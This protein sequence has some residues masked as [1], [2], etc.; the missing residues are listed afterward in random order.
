MKALQTRSPI[1][2][3]YDEPTLG[4]VDLSIWI[5]KDPTA[6]DI[7]NAPNYTLTSD[8]IDSKVI[9]EVSELI[10]S[11]NQY[12]FESDFYQ[13]RDTAIYVLC[14]ANI[15]DTNNNLIE[16]KYNFLKIR[17]GYVQ[18][19]EHTQIIN[20][21]IT[22]NI[23]NFENIGS[24]TTVTG[25]QSDPFGGNNAFLLEDITDSNLVIAK[26]PLNLTGLHTTSFFIK[27]GINDFY[28]IRTSEGIT[29]RVIF[30]LS[31]NE[32]TFV[33]SEVIAYDLLIVN[34]GFVKISIVTELDLN[35]FF[36]VSSINLIQPESLTLFNPTVVK[37]NYINQTASDLVLQDNTEIFTT[38]DI[39]IEVLFDRKRTNGF[40]GFDSNFKDI[41]DSSPTITS[42]SYNINFADI[43]QDRVIADGGTFESD[44]CLINYL[45]EI[46][47]YDEANDD[48]LIFDDLSGIRTTQLFAF[49]ELCEPKYTPVKIS[50]INRFGVIQDL[51]FFKKRVDSYNTSEEDYKAN[52][53]T[54]GE[55]Y[56][57]LGQRRVYN[58]QAQASVKISSGFY[59]ESFNT[60]FRQLL[61]SE[62]YWI[63]DEPAILTDSKW[64][65]KTKVNDKLINYDFD[66]DFA[67]DDIN[68]IR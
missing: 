30:D 36:R 9:F 68:S 61:Y 46:G 41:F 53:I 18:R 64:T 2:L 25:S 8:A 63:D 52:I 58:K 56:P 10:R 6:L 57:H 50:F 31:V 67:N 54:N 14:R 48:I 11:A 5:S 29:K 62:M 45:D 4:K 21:N 66:F 33:G 1:H 22:S 60:V 39:S 20:N 59:P 35:S 27:K 47:S 13:H 51:V 43:F 16:P 37:G 42:T 17:D 34:N 28:D 24:N 7:N 40:Y 65:E 3:Y 12:E 26:T 38:N 23:N 19:N 49:S 32:F 15:F 55:V 44:E